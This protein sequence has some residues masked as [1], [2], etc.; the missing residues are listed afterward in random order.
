MRRSG[1]IVEFSIPFFK[2]VNSV[3]E[4]AELTDDIEF[5]LKTTDDLNK[6]A[7]T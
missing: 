4:H 7:E 6:L 5:P 3:A 1:C 2:K